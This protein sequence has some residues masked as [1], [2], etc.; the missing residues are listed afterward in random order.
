KGKGQ[1]EHPQY[2]QLTLLVLTGLFQEQ[3]GQHHRHH[4]DGKIDE[5]DKPPGSLYPA[6]MYKIAAKEL[7]QDGCHTL[8]DTIIAKSPVPIIA[9]PEVQVDQRDSLR[10]HKG[11]G[12]TLKKPECDQRADRT[13]HSAKHRG[14]RKGQQ[15]PDKHL[16]SS[17]LI[18][19]AAP[20][21]KED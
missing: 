5:K 1:Q 8:H 9:F 7:S 3:R 2:I 11:G 12:Y 18:P 21:N 17:K 10:H 19:D 13:C 15:P 14:H 16:F 20:R 4:A 6:R